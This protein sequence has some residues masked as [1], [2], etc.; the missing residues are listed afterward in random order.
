MIKQHHVLRFN[1]L[2]KFNNIVHGFST[3]FF[4]SLRPSDSKYQQSFN[5]F[6]DAF[7]VKIQQ[8]VKMNQIHSNLVQIVTKKDYGQIISDTDGLITVE[9]EVFLAV[10]TG[11]CIPLFFYDQK[12]EI[13]AAVHAGWRGLFSEIIKETIFL[14]ICCSNV[15]KIVFIVSFNKS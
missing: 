13:I 9:P 10:I 3:N 8:V 14:P 15:C 11:D 2:A 6:T 5:K 1:N 7:G 12:K 4:G